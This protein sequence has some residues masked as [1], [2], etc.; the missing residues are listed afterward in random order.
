M[1]SP[2]PPAP[3]V[4]HILHALR[5]SGAE[6]MLRLAAPIVHAQ[7]LEQHILADGITVGDYAPTLQEA[8]FTI[9]HRPC[10]TW[11]I[12]HWWR[13]YYFLKQHQFT[14]IHNHTEQNF[15]WYLLTARLA[16][17]SQLVSTVHSA[18]NFRGQV[19]WRRG[20]YRWLA[21]NILG[22]QF[23]AIGP[24]VAQVEIDTY[25]NPTTLIPN[26]LDE[27]LFVP[28]RNLIERTEAR[29]HFSIPDAAVALISVGSCTENKNHGA[30]LEAL[31]TLRAKVSQPL[32]YLHVGEG[33]THVAEQHQ[34]HRLG[35]SEM[36]HFVG[37]LHDVRQ[38][39]L[40]A[41]IFVMSSFL[42]G[43]GNSLLEALSCG[44]PSVVYDVY[45]L[46]DLVIDGKTGRCVT[47]NPA[48]LADAL[49]ELIER[50][51]LRH[52]YGSAGRDFVRQNYSMHDSL[53]RLLPLYGLS[54]AEVSMVSQTDN[55]SAVS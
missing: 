6:V 42:E 46:R 51:D 28:A 33:H 20:A 21:R 8:G 53:A 29:Q 2:T 16:G 52:H 54:N 31:A 35:V 44:V 38:A 11:S 12:A 18:F 19:R 14:I 26:W 45:G 1:L 55:F 47:P 5:F 22:A 40:A 24:S 43:L 34:A 17:I 3:K 50:P 49:S 48:A 4:L 37:Q 36:T 39:L 23:T 32:I 41:D 7:G 15:F 27:Q 25:G 13:L 9:H 30:I 10:S